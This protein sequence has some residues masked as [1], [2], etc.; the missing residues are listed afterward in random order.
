M[1]RISENHPCLQGLTVKQRKEEVLKRR[2]PDYKERQHKARRRIAL[3]GLLGI[4]VTG[5][6]A[7]DHFL[8]VLCASVVGIA[9]MAPYAMHRE[10]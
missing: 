3:V 4:L 10:N 7:E 9:M 6:L 1:K 5:L 8:L 2:F